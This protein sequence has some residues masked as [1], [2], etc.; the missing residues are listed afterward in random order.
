MSNIANVYG[1][2]TNFRT[3]RESLAV[4]ELERAVREI[5]ERLQW[6]ETTNN[7]MPSPIEAQHQEYYRPDK[8]KGISGSSAA[9]SGRAS[10]P[11]SSQ[12]YHDSAEFARAR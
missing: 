6:T 4:I 12:D 1:L 9:N 8:G 3:P 2:Q 10:S 11:V 7:K 5:G